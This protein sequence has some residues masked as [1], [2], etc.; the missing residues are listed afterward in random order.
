MK[1]I[2]LAI[3]TAGLLIGCGVPEEEAAPVEPPFVLSG[4]DDLI[5]TWNHCS[6]NLDG[7]SLRLRHRYTINRIGEF[8]LAVYYGKNCAGVVELHSTERG[9][10]IK[11]TLHE[12]SLAFSYIG[13][14][15]GLT[16]YTTDYTFDDAKTMSALILGDTRIFR[17]NN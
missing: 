6:N 7:S 15:D 14:A 11:V 9:R 4:Y 2:L 16:Y 1:K 10:N 8:Y 13:V 5:G 17:K 3:L 12:N